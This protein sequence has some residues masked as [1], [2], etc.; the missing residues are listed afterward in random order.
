VFLNRKTETLFEQVFREAE[1]RFAF[2][3][4][5]L[6][7]ECDR[8]TFYVKLA[9]GSQLP[10]MIKWLKQ[11]FSAR[12]NARYQRKGHVWGGRAKVKPWTA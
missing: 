2:D 6:V 5:D 10:V 4:H 12:F 9:N 1:E 11:T 7:I 8:V 3:L